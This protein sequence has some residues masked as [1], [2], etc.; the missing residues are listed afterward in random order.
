MKSTILRRCCTP[1][2]ATLGL[3]AVGAAPA[4]ATATST[5]TPIS[6][7][8]TNTCNG[9][10]VTYS[11]TEHLVLEMTNNTTQASAHD[12]IVNATGV[13]APSGDRYRVVA[14]GNAETSQVSAFEATAVIR[15]EYVSQGS[16]PNFFADELVHV[17]FNAK[18]QLTAVVEKITPEGCSG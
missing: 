2:A 1:L 17:T 13:G 9:D 7:T 3:L 14:V 6:G 12:D 16:D 15:I 18:G 4:L 11:G 10:L 8:F 5:N